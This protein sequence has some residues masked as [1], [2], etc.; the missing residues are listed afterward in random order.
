MTIGTRYFALVTIF[1]SGEKH[2]INTLLR[3]YRIRSHK[4]SNFEKKKKKRMNTDQVFNSTSKSLEWVHSSHRTQDFL[5]SSWV[6]KLT[7]HNTFLVA[8]LESR[9]T[10]VH[11]AAGSNHI[12]EMD[13]CGFWTALHLHHCY[14]GVH[15]YEKWLK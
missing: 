7:A 10:A 14:A 15:S 13:V 11:E 12:W 2:E 5:F 1:F 6:K 3:V 4:K 8:N 9:V